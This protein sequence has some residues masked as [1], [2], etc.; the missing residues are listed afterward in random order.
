MSQAKK[1]A[2]K[3]IAKRGSGGKRMR[4]DTPEKVC[5][6]IDQDVAA[7]MWTR[8]IRGRAGKR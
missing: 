1:I 8:W 7:L 6:I 3:T 2:A 5:L 4:I